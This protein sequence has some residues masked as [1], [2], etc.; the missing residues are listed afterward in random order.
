MATFNKDAFLNNVVTAKMETARIPFPEGEH[1]V[2]I[3]DIDIKDGTIK[4]GENAGKSWAQL[5]LKCDAKDPNV[6]AE[7]GFDGDTPARISAFVFLDLD[8]ENG[9]LAVGPNQ[10]VELGKIRAAVG[11]NEEGE[12]WTLMNLRGA[13]MGIVVKHTLNDKQETRAEIAGYFN[14]DDDE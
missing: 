11:Q 4:N 1:A 10:N 5:I 9:T 12:E 6:A 14:L 8:H 2:N 3:V 7:M 13:D